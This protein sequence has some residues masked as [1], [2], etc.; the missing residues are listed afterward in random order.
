MA[1]YAPPK[2]NITDHFNPLD[3][4]SKDD[5]KEGDALINIMAPP[6][7]DQGIAFLKDD[8][9]LHTSSN[10]VFDDNTN[11]LQLNGSLNIAGPSTFSDS[12]LVKNALKHMKIG[13]ESANMNSLTCTGPLAGCTL[14][15][16]YPLYVKASSTDSANPR[17]GISFQTSNFTVSYPP[18]ADMVY[19][20][21]ATSPPR[22]ELQF[23]LTTSNSTRQKIMGIA[24]DKVEINK[25]LQVNGIQNI[26]AKLGIGTTES[27]T[28]TPLS[29]F[30]HAVGEKLTLYDGGSA[31]NYYG[32]GISAGNFNI[33][34]D[35][36]AEFAFYKGGKNGNGT[37]LLRIKNN[38]DL[39]VTKS[40]NVADTANLTKVTINGATP[41]LSRLTFNNDI[42]PKITFYSTD[43]INSSGFGTSSQSIGGVARHTFNAHVENDNAEFHWYSGGYNGIAGS[44]KQ[45]MRLYWS[46]F[47]NRPQL[48]IGTGLSREYQ[49]ELEQ[50]SAGKPGFS[51]YW[52]NSSD[53][54]IK[55]NIEN[56]DLD[57]CYNVVKNLPLKRFKFKD[58]IYEAQHINNDTFGLGFIAQDAQLYFPKSVSTRKLHGIEDCLTLNQDQIMK[59]LYGTVQKLMQQVEGLQTE[60]SELKKM[61]F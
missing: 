38:G 13:I 25:N 26:S 45:L 56:A 4:A 57:I 58:G 15:D 6:L 60:I 54:R 43:Q 39:Q 40:L 28:L 1:S 20:R 53:E 36:A 19:Q 3:F 55:E 27:L 34:T 11:A 16:E 49:L 37:Q 51:G 44:S 21:L 24:H 61:A 7:I 23:N 18:D 9:K 59:A 17:V 31:T 22:G 52:T 50:D 14:Y 32:F 48:Y 35:V 46:G 41:S 5:D 47:Y 10:L 42:E 8:G 30:P 12:L 33:H 29:I 2:H